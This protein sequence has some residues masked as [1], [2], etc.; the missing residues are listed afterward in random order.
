MRTRGD[1]QL[2]DLRADLG[3]MCGLT[4]VA[5]RH[6]TRGLLEVQTL[7]RRQVSPS[8]TLSGSASLV[9][10]RKKRARVLARQAPVT[11]SRAVVASIRIAADAGGGWPRRARRADVPASPPVRR[12]AW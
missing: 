4:R 7:A 6:A 12:A 1:R 11:C 8:P 5:A 10:G 9:G 2:E 3:R